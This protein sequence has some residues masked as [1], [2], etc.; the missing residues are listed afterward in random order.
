M[1]SS[2]A[3]RVVPPG[4]GLHQAVDRVDYVL[5]QPPDA[6]VVLAVLP[7]HQRLPVDPD[8]LVKK[9]LFTG[10]AS[11]H[12]S[13]LFGLLAIMRCTRR[14]GQLNTLFKARIIYSRIVW[15]QQPVKDV[16]HACHSAD[17]RRGL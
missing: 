3:P 2:G 17:S 16:H 1:R 13:G 10:A 15:Y 11:D 4:D 8:F 6:D 9:R 7:L 5:G 14:V 12:Q